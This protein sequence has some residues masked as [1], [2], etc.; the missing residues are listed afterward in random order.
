MSAVVAEGIH[1]DID[2]GLG[3]I[4][5]EDGAVGDGSQVPGDR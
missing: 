3:V 2:V 4:H 5:G 1:Q